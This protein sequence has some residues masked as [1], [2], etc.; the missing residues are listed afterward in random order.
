MQGKATNPGACAWQYL[1]IEA[2]T[3]VKVPL[4]Q[5][6]DTVVIAQRCNELGA[7]GWELVSVVP[8]AAGNAATCELR[9]FF[10]RPLPAP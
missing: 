1:V 3:H 10:K 9:L 7:Q 8:L 5:H 4:R 6:N 2:A